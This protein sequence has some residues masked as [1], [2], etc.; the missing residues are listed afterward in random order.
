MSG[1]KLQKVLA[2]H[3]LG[4]RREME[5]WVSAGRVMVD[6]EV[7]HTGQRV[8][9]SSVIEVDGKTLRTRTETPR[10]L[11]MNKNVGV[12]CTRRDPEGRET[13]FANLPKLQGG[14]WVTVGRLDVNTSG[15]L[16]FTNNGTLANKLMHPSTGLDREYAVRVDGRLTDEEIETLT[17]GVMIDDAMCRFSDLRHY[18]GRGR[19]HWY[20]AVLLE[21]RNHEVRNLLASVGR[22][23]S[24]L[25]RVRYGPVVLP[26]YLRAGK[27]TEMAA[28][29]VAA[30]CKLVDLPYRVPAQAARKGTPSSG[31]RKKKASMLLPYPE[32]R[33]RN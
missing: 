11:V 23:V 21:G 16:V 33:G 27:V 29:D 17:T 28:E 15:L 1:E 26:S 32:L 25:K 22:V 30:L 12:I 20:H 4:S 3:G 8:S 14:R 13:V 19:N 9:A 31:P 6:G 18:D 24:R 5:R 2:D 10:V 7:A